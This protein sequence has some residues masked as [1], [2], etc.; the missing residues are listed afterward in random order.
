MD[1]GITSSRNDLVLTVFINTE[2]NNLTD[3]IRLSPPREATSSSVTEEFPN[4]L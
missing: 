2:L 4:I 1:P 3:S